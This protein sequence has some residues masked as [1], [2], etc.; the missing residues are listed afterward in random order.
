MEHVYLEYDHGGA[1]SAETYA[2][3]LPQ[4]MWA[5][6]ITLESHAIS[7]NVDYIDEGVGHPAGTVLYHLVNPQALFIERDADL[8]QPLESGEDLQLFNAATSFEELKA[9]VLARVSPDQD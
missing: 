8:V 4:A 2:A 9:E 6:F 1:F 5:I 3:N 7:E